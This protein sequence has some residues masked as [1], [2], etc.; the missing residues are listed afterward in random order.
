MR[1]LTT[2]FLLPAVLGLLCALPAGTFGQDEDPAL[3]PSPPTA[4][5]QD[6]IGMAVDEEEVILAPERSASEELIS[7]TLDDVP[8]VD[9]VRMFT[10]ISGAN[11]IANAE[12]LQGNVTVNLT[13][14]AW[15]PALSSILDM[16]SLGLVEKT[17]GSGVYSIVLRAADAPEPMITKSF[18]LNF[19]TVVDVS[20]VLQSMLAEGATLSEFPSRNIIVVRST[21]ENLSDIQGLLEQIDVP[22]EQV[23]VETKFLELSDEA[24]EK[25]GIRWD[26]LEEFGVGGQIGPFTRSETLEKT[27]TR[28][29]QLSRYDLRQNSD[30]LNN[31][32]D[33]YGQ[34]YEIESLEIVEKPDGTFVEFSN[35]DPTRRVSDTINKGQDVTSDILDTFTKTIT[36]SQSAILELDSFHVLLSALR[37]T[38]GVTIISN[39]KIIVASGSTNAL[40]SVGNREPIIKTEVSRGTTDSPGDK[41]TSQLDTAI[42]TEYIKQGY[43]QTGID[44]RVIP[45]VKTEE[46]IEARIQPKLIR[47]ILPDKTVGDNSWPRISVKEIRT[48][49]TLRSGQTVAIGGLTDTQDDKQV[50]KVPLL[51][52]LPLIGKYLFRHTADTTRRTEMIIFVTLALAQPD[53]LYEDIGIPSNSQL[54][55]KQRIRDR[56]RQEQFKDDMENLEDAS[57]VE[58]AIKADKEKAHLLQRRK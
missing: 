50:T 2:R 38:D 16:H 26:S 41:I 44:L 37:R 20:P 47:R 39:P 7:I 40:F 45:V 14:V 53:T 27:K 52:D 13:D 10:R 19:S 55:H 21:S 33:L 15:K 34:P 8:L 6:F 56:G 30:T 36:E 23:C 54:V 51:G 3:D 46:L 25:L 17:L 58:A 35:L 42:N 31:L 11:I 1:H 43:L 5:P 29:D 28:E 4:D 48:K 18:Q 32:Y 12:D 57:R 24:S 9:V 49:F 22:T